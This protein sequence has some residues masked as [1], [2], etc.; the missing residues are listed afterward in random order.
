MST[1]LLFLILAA[2]GLMNYQFYLAF[3]VP[4]LERRKAFKLLTTEEIEDL[5]Q[6]LTSDHFFKLGAELKLPTIN[7]KSLRR[8]PKN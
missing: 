7:L 2:I 6:K 3:L 8:S 1:I 4:E 5:R